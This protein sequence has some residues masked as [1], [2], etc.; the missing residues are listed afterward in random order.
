MD[1]AK[2]NLATKYEEPSS[3]GH[4]LY[5]L[6]L[7]HNPKYKKD[8]RPLKVLWT[9]KEKRDLTNLV[10]DDLKTSYSLHLIEIVEELTGGLHNHACIYFDKVPLLKGIKVKDFHFR[11]EK[12][13]DTAR[14][15][16]YIRKTLHY[17]F[18]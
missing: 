11:W 12:I 1:K 9:D 4:I 7:K 13:Y 18:I 2:P 10:L 5:A 14:W 15:Q 8:M 6:T 3:Q 16:S 17:T